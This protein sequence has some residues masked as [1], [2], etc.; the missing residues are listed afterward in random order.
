MGGA[1]KPGLA[2]RRAA[3]RPLLIVGL[4]VAPVAISSAQ[5]PLD[6]GGVTV[7]EELSGARAQV[8]ELTRTRE[9]LSREGV[10]LDRR[11]NSLRDRVRHDARALYRMRRAAPLSFAGGISA[12]LSRLSRV[13]R[14]ERALISES[15]QMRDARSRVASL[16]RQRSQAEQR[17]RDLAARVEGL[18]ARQ[19]SLEA[20]ARDA[21]FGGASFDS[22]PVAPLPSLASADGYGS[23]RVVGTASDLGSF[24]QLRGRLTLPVAGTARFADAQIEAGPALRVQAAPSSSVRAVAPGRVAF[25]G[26]QVGMGLVVIV[27][28]QGGFFSVYAGLGVAAP[29]VGDRVGAGVPL[30]HTSAGGMFD[31][32]VRRGTRALDPRSWLGI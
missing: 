11:A 30:G 8:E 23:L 3:L 29:S 9:Q 20:Q 2:L 1:P 22:L 31:F 5:L 26:R 32:Q 21:I 17:L 16:Q 18:E 14:L 13:S 4:A 15:R 6:V 7:D 19:A 25:V 24:A 27:E 28:H 12:M 10:E